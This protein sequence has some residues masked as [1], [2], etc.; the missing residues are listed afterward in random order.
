MS[1]LISTLNHNLPELTDNLIDQV[2]RD[3]DPSW[4]IMVVDNGSKEEKAKS[5]THTLEENAFF[6]GGFNLILDYFLNETNH[7]F[8]AVLNNDLIFHG[9]GF[10]K[11]AIDAMTK[12]G[13]Q[14]YSPAV[15]NASIEQCKWKQ[16]WNWGTGDV[17][18]VKWIDFQCPFL[19]REICKI[20][21]EY[22]QQLIYGWGLDFYTGIIASQNEMRIGVDDF[23]TLCHLN[24]QTFKQNK[25]NIGINEFCR[26][27][28][29]N[30][31]VYFDRHYKDE[32]RDLWTYA[33]NYNRYNE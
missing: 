18:A 23:Y 9:H 29:S 27:A 25:I 28:Q 14:V 5:T 30:M 4:E 7:E 6:G 21:K 11:R 3:F 13:L 10:I 22:P 12:Y 15:I 24:S 1:I 16:M 8:L 20:I 33:E 31:E 26:N 19:H 2:K 17:R 32:F